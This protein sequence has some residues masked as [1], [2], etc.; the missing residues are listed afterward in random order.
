MADSF[1]RH[2]LQITNM[3]ETENTQIVE[4]SGKTRLAFTEAGTEHRDH[5]PLLLVHGSLCD[6]RYWEPQ[7]QAFAAHRHVISV[8]LPHYFPVAEQGATSHFSIQAHVD[9]LLSLIHDQQWGQVTL[10]GHSRGGC[11][12]FHLASQDPSV[13]NS[14]VLSDPGA[15]PD[16]A[17][18]SDLPRTAAYDDNDPRMLATGLIA[19]GDIDGGLQMFVD[20]V[21]RPG[22]WDRSGDQFKTMARDNAHTLSMQIRDVL[23]LYT[24]AQASMVTVPTLILN[25]DKSPPGFLAT[26][27]TL[28]EWMPYA[29][30]SIIRGASHGMNLSHA[31][32]FN[33]QVLEFVG[34]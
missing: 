4:L 17:P 25:G 22:F 9:A 12:A 14:L 6:Y 28:A 11:V 33:R 26:S 18:G 10:V 30:R 8:S 2:R 21:S 13:L 31:S 7:I 23:P 1:R 29:R 32:E 20:A 15:K 3:L 24:R 27:S 34:A 16:N 19:R 5:A